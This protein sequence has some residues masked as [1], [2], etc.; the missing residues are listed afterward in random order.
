MVYTQKHDEV[1]RHYDVKMF[2]LL[3]ESKFP[4]SSHNSNMSDKIKNLG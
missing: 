2:N 1:R 3:A 4:Q